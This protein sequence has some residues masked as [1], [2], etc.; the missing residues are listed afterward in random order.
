MC[1]HDVIHPIPAALPPPQESSKCTTFPGASR[2]HREETH[3]TFGRSEPGRT[4]A[5]YQIRD[6]CR[7][8]S[9]ATSPKPAWFIITSEEIGIIHR[10]LS[11]IEQNGP[12]HRNE[13]AREISRIL[14]TV[15]RRLA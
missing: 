2:D 11:E 3:G 8:A 12:E 1:L 10:H 15:E 13:C 9:S 5:E 4:D 6:Q 14:E 7:E